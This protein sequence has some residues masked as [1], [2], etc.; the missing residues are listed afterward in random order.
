MFHKNRYQIKCNNENK[1]NIAYCI[2][3]LLIMI[4]IEEIKKHKQIK[5]MRNENSIKQQCR[6]M[7]VKRAVTSLPPPPPPPKKFNIRKFIS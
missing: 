2:V 3:N 6:L 4:I 1:S 7:S 5:H